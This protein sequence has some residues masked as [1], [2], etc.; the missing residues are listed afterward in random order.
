MLV[1]NTS[2]QQICIQIPIDEFKSILDLIYTMSFWE[3]AG[4]GVGGS[5]GPYWQS[6]RNPLYKQYADKLLEL[7]NVYL[8]FCSNEVIYPYTFTLLFVGEL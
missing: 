7:G 3:N 4:P 1:A 2:P 5:Y 6:E 8:C